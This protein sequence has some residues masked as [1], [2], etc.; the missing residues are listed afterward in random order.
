MGIG[1][2]AIKAGEAFVRI[3]GNDADLQKTLEAAKQKL[4]GFSGSASQF[5]DRI[6]KTF[7]GKIVT[8]LTGFFAIGAADK[9]IRD[10]AERMKQ[11]AINGDSFGL[12]DVGAAIGNSIVDGIRSVPIAGALMDLAAEV[13]DRVLWFGGDLHSEDRLAAVEQQRQK[14]QRIF[15][16][17]GSEQAKLL[18]SPIDRERDAFGERI[19]GW[20]RDLMAAG[21][22]MEEARAA[23]AD[24]QQA[25]GALFDERDEIPNVGDWISAALAEVGR[26][27]EI[28]KIL[29]G[30]QNDVADFGL[31][32]AQLLERQL[33]A[34]GA[35]EEQIR[36]AIDATTQLKDMEDAARR[37]NDIEA[38]LN[39]LQRRNDEFGLSEAEITR[40]RLEELGATAEQIDRAMQLSERL[41]AQAPGAESFASSGTFSS[42]I[43]LAFGGDDAVRDNTAATA[44][45]TQK[46]AE[47]ID[48]LA[49]PLWS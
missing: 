14:L 16:E 26:L 27:E 20:M 39:D 48:K 10:I 40:R 25:A 43:Q 17:I 49:P 31:D 29:D 2:G 8:G 12:G 28:K 30:L 7:G 23:V 37:A 36:Q 38:I 11:A 35:T 32:K 33:R 44:H 18:G 21:K 46:I 9:A 4:S 42:A 19:N 45:W 1:A 6:G 41:N 13:S 22:S 3:F 5:A 15:A 34:L 24:L 47:S